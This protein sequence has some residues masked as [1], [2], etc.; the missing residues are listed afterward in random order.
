[1]WNHIELIR[2]FK[3]KLPFPIKILLIELLFYTQSIFY[4]LFPKYI[5]KKDDKR[6][7]YFL[8]STDYSNLG[9]H[10]MSFASILLLKKICPDFEIIEITVNDTIKSF[11]YIMKSIKKGDIICLKGGGNIGI[12]YFR[13]EKIRRKII[14]KF[15]RNKII[16][17][18]Y[19]SNNNLMLLLRDVNSFK[20]LHNEILNSYLTTDIVFYL[21]DYFNTENKNKKYYS[22]CMRNDVEG[23][24]TEKFKEELVQ[25]IKYKFS[26]VVSFDTIKDYFIPLEER[27]NELHKVWDMITMSKV[28]VTDRL[29]GMI[30]SYLLHTPCV[31]LK[32]YNYKL[33][34]QYD[35]LKES[36]SI[37]MITDSKIEKIL[38][39]IEEVEDV[40]DFNLEIINNKVIELEN[41]I[42]SFIY[43]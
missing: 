12:Q 26:N 17:D 19:N 43:E 4:Y 24:Y 21:K 20:L 15:K 2:I 16:I 7:I 27:E 6:T 30:F 38:N 34:G 41:L 8:L 36:N 39:T 18:I 14:K 13:E 1:M 9:D 33:I 28:V 11:K 32:T 31:V 42:R 35:W 40:S 25:S 5:N 37:S 29:H 23:I 22:I 10:A 3:N